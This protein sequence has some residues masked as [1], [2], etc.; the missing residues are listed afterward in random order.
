MSAAV[1]PWI[2]KKKREKE[3]ERGGGEIDLIIFSVV[4]EKNLCEPISERQ[5]QEMINDNYSKGD[6][7]ERRMFIYFYQS[8][9]IGI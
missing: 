3:R 5:S 7:T 9:Y 4:Q 1:W 8:Q 6:K 2:D